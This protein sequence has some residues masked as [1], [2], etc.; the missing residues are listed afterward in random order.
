MGL[1]VERKRKRE[2]G[3]STNRLVPSIIYSFHSLMR[4]LLKTKV[5]AMEKPFFGLNGSMKNR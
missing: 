5:D 2:L 1:D 3:W 4:T